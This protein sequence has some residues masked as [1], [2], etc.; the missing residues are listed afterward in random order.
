MRTPNVKV[1]KLQAGVD[2]FVMTTSRNVFIAY[3]FF[4]DGSLSALLACRHQ[5]GEPSCT[6]KPDEEVYRLTPAEVDREKRYSGW[7]EDISE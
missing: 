3:H 5:Y 7:V 2:Y 1:S 4:P 6:L